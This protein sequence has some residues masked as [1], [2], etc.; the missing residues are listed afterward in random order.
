MAE[1]FDPNVRSFAPAL[2][3]AAAGKLASDDA[4]SAVSS[5][6]PSYEQT[7]GTTDAGR[8]S[9]SFG[10]DAPAEGRVMAP[11]ALRGGGAGQVGRQ[12]RFTWGSGTELSAGETLPPYDLGAERM[13]VVDKKMAV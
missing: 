11:S 8:G 1:Q 13:H 6:F 12:E 2:D 9:G 7:Q 4:D 5:A 3:R 10:G